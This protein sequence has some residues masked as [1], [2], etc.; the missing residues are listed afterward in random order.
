MFINHSSR[1]VTAKIVYYGPGLS[2]KTT[3]LQYIFSVTN[4]K[5]RGELVSIETEIDRTLFFDLLPINVG[6]VNGYQTKFQLYTVP[7]QIF[8]DATRKLVL[9]GADG[10][11]FVI[12]SQELREQASLE[13]YENLITNLGSYNVDINQIP[14]V[15]QFNK[16]DL[17]NIS[18]IERLKKIFNITDTPCFEAVA[19]DGTGVLETLREIST[20]TLRKI[21]ILISQTAEEGVKPTLI[22]FDT[23][24][25][26]EII[27][28]EELPFKKI[29]LES[30]DNFDNVI[31]PG[32]DEE[33]GLFEEIPLIKI[34]SEREYDTLIEDE[35]L[36]FKDLSGSE[37]EEPENII[38]LEK[39]EIIKVEEKLSSG[40]DKRK[41]Y[42][43]IIEDEALPFK[44]LPEEYLED[45]GEVVTLGTDEVIKLDSPSSPIDEKKEYDTVIEEEEL[46]FKT[47][48]EEDLDINIEEPDQYIELG[49][50]EIVKV[51][52][53]SPL[54]IDLKKDFGLKNRERESPSRL[55]ELDIEKMLD[56]K[57]EKE[58]TPQPKP[59][60]GL[61]LDETR[62]SQL[63]EGLVDKSRLTIL[64]KILLKNPHL[65]VE[66]K[67]KDGNLL[68][69]MILKIDP[70]VKKV[71]IIL[72]IKK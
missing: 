30:M 56:L 35:E 68:D 21:K 22:N 4:P 34:G 60:T 16:R 72:D 69:S 55:P 7:G 61:N 32:A 38:T 11:V 36:P 17:K 23:N 50:E 29:S 63:F 19:T 5:T 42:D 3:N 70:E 46:P 40:T 65:M 10:I 45:S 54:E 13:S 51:D 8:Y 31:N 14:L 53:P 44:D 20:L 9:K 1:E 64:K 48:P 33:V 57:R 58:K 71:T 41:D 12:D 25:Q 26:Q 47:L 2:G 49:K 15:F 62:I 27:K 39:D 66:M 52:E 67:D 59:G 6:L 18:T 37:A 43:T 28:R 24:K